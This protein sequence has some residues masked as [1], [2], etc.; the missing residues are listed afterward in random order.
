MRCGLGFGRRSL[1]MDLGV[2]R[3]GSIRVVGRF[4]RAL[5]DTERSSLDTTQIWCQENIGK[6]MGGRGIRLIASK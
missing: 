4:T 5:D 6:Y 2:R 3:Y 1:S